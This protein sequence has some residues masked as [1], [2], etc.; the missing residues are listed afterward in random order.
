MPLNLILLPLDGFGTKTLAC[1]ISKVATA[2]CELAL[3]SVQDPVLWN[4]HQ[5]ISLSDAVSLHKSFL[6]EMASALHMKAV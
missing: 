1:E 2:S 5:D 6:P 3:H 4:S